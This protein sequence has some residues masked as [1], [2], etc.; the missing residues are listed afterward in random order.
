MV[1]SRVNPVVLAQIKSKTMDS[2]CEFLK[3]AEPIYRY[4]IRDLQAENVRLMERNLLLNAA[5]ASLPLQVGWVVPPVQPAVGPQQ[6][7]GQ[8]VV[9]HQAKR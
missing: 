6:V 5:P 3:F 9:G 1:P 8:H 7:L 2:G 4:V